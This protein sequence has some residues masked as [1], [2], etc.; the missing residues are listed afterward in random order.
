MCIYIHIYHTWESQLHT[1]GSQASSYPCS[2]ITL[3][4]A[5]ADNTEMD[6]AVWGR[7]FLYAW[8]LIWLSNYPT[9]GLNQ[10][11]HHNQWWAASWLFYKFLPSVKRKWAHSIT[12][13]HLPFKV[14][15]PLGWHLN[16]TGFL[17]LGMCFWHL[18]RSDSPSEQ[19]YNKDSHMHQ[20]FSLIFQLMNEVTVTVPINTRTFPAPL[21]TSL[22]RTG[23]SINTGHHGLSS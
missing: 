4:S 22:K 17:T 3:V 16:V 2:W 18:K 12:L 1:V 8:K 14:W 11:G 20:V 6:E 15:W 23:C 21:N 13:N 5:W 10:H 7:V 19:I 9:E